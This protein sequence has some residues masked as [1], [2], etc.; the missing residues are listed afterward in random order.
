[1]IKNDE[2]MRSKMIE[3]DEIKDHKND[4]INDH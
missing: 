3:I 4:E 1:M 2:M